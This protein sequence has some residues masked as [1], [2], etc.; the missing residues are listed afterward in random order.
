MSAT[1]STTTGRIIGVRNSARRASRPAK[2]A[3]IEAE[4]RESR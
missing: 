2:R 1:A 4:R 3:P